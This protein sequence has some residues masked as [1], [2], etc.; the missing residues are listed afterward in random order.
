[1]AKFAGL[2]LT[3]DGHGEHEGEGVLSCPGGTGEDE[4]VGK[5][6]GSDGGAEA[7]DGGSVAE[8]LV[9]AGGERG[10]GVHGSID[11]SSSINGPGAIEIV[12]LDDC[13]R[14]CSEAITRAIPQLLEAFMIIGRNPSSPKAASHGICDFPFGDLCA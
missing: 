11:L 10:C 14:R 2:T 5:A 7:L 9:E 12:R 4:R 8:E 3:L 1:M 13:L 6:A